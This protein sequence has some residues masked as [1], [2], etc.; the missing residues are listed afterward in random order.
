MET[1]S[2]QA[3][4]LR[5]QGIGNTSKHSHLSSNF[6]DL[7][8]A[9]KTFL[10]P[11]R[12]YLDNSESAQRLRLHDVLNV[13]SITRH[14]ARKCLEIDDPDARIKDLIAAGNLI[15]KTIEARTPWN[16]LRRT[17]RYSLFDLGRLQ[18]GRH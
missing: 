15:V 2:T 6:T 4:A 12:Y 1:N 9:V 7:D 14:E 8:V 3:N 17:V 16:G 18:Y 10:I 13:G 5:E 11:A